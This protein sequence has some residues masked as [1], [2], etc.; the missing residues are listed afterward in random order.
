MIASRSWIAPMAWGVIILALT[1]AV[2]RA[3]CSW[4]CPMGTLLDWT[5]SRRP[6]RNKLDIPAYWRQVKYF[7]LF[8]VLFAAILGSLT[9]LVLDPITLL[10]RTITSVVLPALSLLITTVEGW[11]Y[12]I[13]LFQPAV[14]WFDG[15]VR[16]S[17]VTE[18]PFFLPNLLLALVF[19]VVLALNII[20]PRFWCRYLCPL[21]GLLGLVSKVA[22]VRYKIDE[23]RCI[24]CKQCA[25]T[26]PTGAIDPERNFAANSAECTTCL[27]C[28]ETCPTGAITFNGHHEP[29]T[30]QRYDPSRRQ[31][32][33]SLSSA[34][35]GAML[36]WVV[37][38]FRKVTPQC[39]R[40]PGASEEH[41]LN[42]CIRCGECIRVCPT[43]G[44]Q[45][46]YSASNWEALWT[47]VLIS[48]LGYC[49][50]S[51]NSCGQVCPTE[52]IPI[53]SLA[54]KRQTVMGIAFI[55]RHLCI[56]WAEG[57]DCIVCEEM[58]PVPAKAIQL[59][60]QIITNSRGETTIVRLP[61]VI[62]GLCIGCG[63]CE[64]QCPV[65]GEAAIRIY[66]DVKQRRRQQGK[67]RAIQQ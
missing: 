37:P 22:Q 18:Q 28:M 38:F 21:G 20:R 16:G 36:L 4:I 10:F 42:Q 32:L 45:P 3:W 41:L 17:L 9:L 39:I 19:A 62:S 30:H 6:D 29:V 31:F 26:C 48:R 23:E 33:T 50:Y 55:D 66:P 63:I 27:D 56:P 12:N 57:R 47:P 52:A 60:E 11:L 34:V 24:S 7:L 14:E 59:E 44:L 49:D 54:E 35:V 5:P 15:L 40:P 13:E 61:S 51:C 25:I 46:S 58:C 64:Y 53:L 8:T 43:G 2:G 65:D 1:I 67:N